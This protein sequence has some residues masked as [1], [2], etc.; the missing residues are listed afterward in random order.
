MFHAKYRNYPDLVRTQFQIIFGSNYQVRTS[1][2][3]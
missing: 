1:L 3:A 2:E